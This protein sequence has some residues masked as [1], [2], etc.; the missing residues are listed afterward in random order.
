M[1]AGALCRDAFA[2]PLT[3][4]GDGGDG[5]LPRQDHLDAARSAGACLG[6]RLAGR[7]PGKDV[8]PIKEGDVVVIAAFDDIPEHLFRVEE[9]FEDHVTGIALDGPLAC[10]CC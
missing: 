8:N 6:P 3:A 9:V 1:V 7:D 2:C 4:C 5:G 10:V